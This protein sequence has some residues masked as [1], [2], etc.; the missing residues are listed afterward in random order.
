MALERTIVKQIMGHI[1]SIGGLCIKVH[2]GAYQMPG[3]SDILAC[4]DGRFYAFEVKV[5]SPA[6]KYTTEAQELFLNRVAASGGYS[7]AVTCVEDVI[8]IINESLEVM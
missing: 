8:S 7:G 2:G 4:I 6:S 3:I 5:K 1:T